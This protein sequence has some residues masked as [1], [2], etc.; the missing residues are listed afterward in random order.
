MTIKH[1]TLGD[2]EK[3]E[4]LAE[5]VHN[6][7]S[8][9]VSDMKKYKIDVIGVEVATAVYRLDECA[10][11]IVEPGIMYMDSSISYGLEGKVKGAVFDRGE[12]DRSPTDLIEKIEG[13][14]DTLSKFARTTGRPNAM[15]ENMAATVKENK[16][17]KRVNKGPRRT[18]K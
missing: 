8:S 18:K 13:T 4:K 10:R 16:G 15:I 7:F 12:V 3:A 6:F 17:A 5:M 11:W 9:A 14:I 1:W 2:M